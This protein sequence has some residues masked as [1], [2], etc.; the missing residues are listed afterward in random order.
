MAGQKLSRRP[1]CAAFHRCLSAAFPR[2][3]A[4]LRGGVRVLEEW[5]LAR[6]APAPARA[7]SCALHLLCRDAGFLHDAGLMVWLGWV[8]TRCCCVRLCTCSCFVD[9]LLPVSPLQARLRAPVRCI[10]CAGML[11]VC[12]ARLL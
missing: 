7:C 1:R 2:D 9:T 6:S 3:A 5:V 11:D 8:C 4:R 10:C 12:D